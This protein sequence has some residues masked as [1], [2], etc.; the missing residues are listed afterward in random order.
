MSIN[1]LYM[2]VFYHREPKS[3]NPPF[4]AWQ[5]R[6][7]SA[8]W[9]FVALLLNNRGKAAV[10]G[11][12]YGDG[13]SGLRFRCHWCARARAVS[14]RKVRGRKPSCRG[15]ARSRWRESPRTK[16]RASSCRKDRDGRC[17]TA[18]TRRI[19]FDK[20]TAFA[21][22]GSRRAREESCCLF[23]SRHHRMQ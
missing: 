7:I 14:L 18:W 12:S 22:K 5:T 8:L 21:S 10:C 11:A 16:R 13:R 3:V 19:R 2:A 4:L 6:T 15:Q 20:N 23:R 9:S 17:R 1:T